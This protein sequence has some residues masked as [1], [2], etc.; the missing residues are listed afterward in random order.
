MTEFRE[1]IRMR[2]RILFTLLSIT[3]FFLTGLVIKKIL[4]LF[5]IS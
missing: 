4:Q 2:S 5:C 3:I 1:A